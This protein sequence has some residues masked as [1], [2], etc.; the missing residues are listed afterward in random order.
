MALLLFAI[1][2]FCY[3]AILLFCYFEAS[4]TLI[5]IQ[6]KLKTIF[7]LNRNGFKNLYWT[8]SLLGLVSIVLIVFSVDKN[9]LNVDRWSAMEVGIK[10]LLNGEYPYTATDHLNGRTSNFPGLFILGL[11]PYILG[12][13]G[14]LQ[15][16]NFVILVYFLHKLF[17]I[18]IALLYLLLVFISPA[19]WWEIYVASDMMTN[20]FII[21]YVVLWVDRLRP[22]VLSSSPF[23]AGILLSTLVL[24]RGIVLIPLALYFTKKFFLINLKAKF[25]FLLAGTIWGSFLILLVLLNVPDLETLLNFNPLILQTTQVPS[26]FILISLILPFILSFYHKGIPVNYF[27]YAVILLLLPVSIGFIIKIWEYGFIITLLESKFDISY[28]SLVFPFLIYAIVN[29]NKELIIS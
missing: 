4:Y 25:K 12:N 2:L 5:N 7:K 21:F 15:V 8:L 11:I 19:F 24:T 26:S 27:N 1:L 18:K 10:A 17:P 28:L 20:L 6:S 13:I 22:K 16:F 14:L 9:T 29:Q 23:I 3:F